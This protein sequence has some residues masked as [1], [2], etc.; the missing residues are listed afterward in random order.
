MDAVWTRE[1][2]NVTE[3]R[4]LRVA[5]HPITF[6]QFLDVTDEN[7]DFELVNGVLVERMAAQ[8]P[9]ERR[10][11][12]LLFLL[13]GYVRK[14]RLGTVLGSRSAVEI[15][16][17]SGRLPDLMFIRAE[18][19]DIIQNK[20]IYGAPDLVVEIVSPS[21]TRGDL[22]AL[23]ADYRAIGVA[24]VVFWDADGGEVR[25]LRRTADGYAEE[26][27][28]DGEYRSAVVPRFHLTVADMLADPLPD[29]T[30]LLDRLL[31]EAP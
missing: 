6:E 8:Y 22:I 21:N 12:W 11:V 4:S 13:N 25:V 2:E 9:H 24:E 7:D 16:Q 3:T 28:T 15:S 18:R 26:R 20:A 23:E 5:H 19:A 30:D 31:A 27:L 17:F 14:R 10:F 29:E 1:T